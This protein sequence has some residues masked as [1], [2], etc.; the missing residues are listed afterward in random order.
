MRTDDETSL[1]LPDSVEI[2]SDE[3]DTGW[4]CFKVE[5]P[6][7]FVRLAYWRGSP[8]YGRGKCFDFCALHFRYGLRPGEREQARTAKEALRV[9]GYKVMLHSIQIARSSNE[10]R[11]TGSD[12]I[13]DS[14]CIR[15]Q[16]GAGP[17][18]NPRNCLTLGSLAG[19]PVRHLTPKPSACAAINSF[20]LPLP[21]HKYFPLINLCFYRL[22]HA[23]SDDNR[24]TQRLVFLFIEGLRREIRLFRLQG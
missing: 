1:V 8:A 18:S 24:R 6:L 10:G 12:R 13:R 3:S 22:V 21:L 16:S 23:H 7:E 15:T 9:A 19:L 5:G 14:R 4:A 2:E 20:P 11:S 17:G